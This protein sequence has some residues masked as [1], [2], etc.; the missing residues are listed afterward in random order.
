MKRNIHHKQISFIAGARSQNEQDLRNNMKFLKIPEASIESIGW[1][2]SWDA[3]I[4]MVSFD[5]LDASL[6]NLQ[7]FQIVP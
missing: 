4:L 3:N 6:R 1:L 7:E 2:P 5:G